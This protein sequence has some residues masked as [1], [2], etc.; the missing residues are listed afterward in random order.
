[1][2]GQRVLIRRHLAS[3]LIP[4]S[5]GLA[6]AWVAIA[7]SYTPGTVE[8]EDIYDLEDWFRNQQA[9]FLPL[10]PPS[11]DPFMQTGDPGAL[12]F[13]P[14]DFPA[15]CKGALIG[16]IEYGAPVYDLFLV[17]DPASRDFMIYNAACEEVCSLSAPAG[18]D[19]SAFARK[20]YPELY[21]GDYTAG[22][23]AW[24]L[25]LHD[26]ARIQISVRLVPSDFFETYLATKQEADALVA[27][28]LEGL[29]M[30]CSGTEA[31]T[32]LWVCA[33]GPESGWSNQVQVTVHV[34]PG[35]TNKVDVYSVD[36]TGLDGTNT[37]WY[38]VATNLEA[39]GTNDDIPGNPFWGSERPG[40]GIQE[41]GEIQWLG[42]QDCWQPPA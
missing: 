27:M 42:S 29:S 26:P 5:L 21:S 17:E 41:S 6:L 4:V 28:S 20:R 22:Q 18:Y 3:G 11:E 9:R 12:P 15:E 31:Y 1:M 8:I 38:A 14:T 7:Q 23:I 19:P 35:F 2:N 37:V 33:E 40:K 13:D 10:M 16:Q 32:G 34:P 39:V 30:M 25:D 24:I 36:T